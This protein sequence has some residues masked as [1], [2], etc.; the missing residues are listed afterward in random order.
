MEF[1]FFTLPPA[2]SRLVSHAR[3]QAFYVAASALAHFLAIRRGLRS[4]TDRLGMLARR[5]LP[6][7]RVRH[8][9]GRSSDP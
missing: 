8:E 6:I 5:R 3:A 1:L 9:G 4:T 7:P 2:R